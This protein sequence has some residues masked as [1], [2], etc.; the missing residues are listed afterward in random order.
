MAGA[1]DKKKNAAKKILYA[2]FE[3]ERYADAEAMLVEWNLCRD[4][5]HMDGGAHLSL[6]AQRCVLRATKC[7]ESADRGRVASGMLSSLGWHA[8][9][10]E[11]PDVLE[12]KKPLSPSQTW[13]IYVSLSCMSDPHELVADLLGAFDATDLLELTSGDRTLLHACASQLF[14][15]QSLEE[16]GERM[17]SFIESA[18]DRY[19]TAVDSYGYRPVDILLEI[20][21]RDDR[22]GEYWPSPPEAWISA[23]TPRSASA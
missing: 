23:F 4:I 11:W 5:T 8:I 3:A 17:L 9:K 22:H 18:P 15:H 6:A 2:L 14:G 12:K 19:K 1:P 10:E 20:P 7:G 13:F 21:H 16:G